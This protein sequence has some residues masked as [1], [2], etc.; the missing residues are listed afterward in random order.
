MG[1]APRLL[2][3]FLLLGSAPTQV[4]FCTCGLRS[5][6]ELL[7]AKN[8]RFREWP[9]TSGWRAVL[10][11]CGVS[12]YGVGR[13]SAANGQEQIADAGS[14]CPVDLS[15]GANEGEKKNTEELIEGYSCQLPMDSYRKVTSAALGTAAMKTKLLADQEEREVQRLA[16]IIV[17]NQLK[18]LS[19][20]LKQLGDIDAV[21]EKER[22]QMERNRQRFQS[23]R[24]RF[25]SAR[26]HSSGA[27]TQMPVVEPAGPLVRPAGPIPSSPAM[28]S[29]AVIAPGGLMP[30]GPVIT[31]GGLMPSGQ[32]LPSHMLRPT[33]YTIGPGGMTMPASS[34]MVKPS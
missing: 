19:T 17:D 3:S 10:I 28:P 29:G 22:E 20:K 21:L 6:L 33:L 13:R 2:W 7:T 12:F 23:E 32:V 30:S 18:K 24:S 27:A 16:A 9:T 5:V 1:L 8:V 15:E 34:P 14:S 26:L 11:V 4:Y 31:P 25:L